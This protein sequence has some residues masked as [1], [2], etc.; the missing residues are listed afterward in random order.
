MTV[1]LKV[2]QAAHIILSLSL[3]FDYCLRSAHSA[4]AG[5]ATLTHPHMQSP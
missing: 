5:P 1:L 2:V 3:P 4:T